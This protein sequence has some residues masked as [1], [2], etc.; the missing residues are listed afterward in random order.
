MLKNE[1]IYL[2]LIIFLSGCESIKSLTESIGFKSLNK[3]NEVVEKDIEISKPCNG[4]GFMTNNEYFRASAFGE[5]EDLRQ[6]QDKAMAEANDR[7]AAAIYHTIES[8]SDKYAASAG[9]NLSEDFK[10][11]I[12]SIAHDVVDQKLNNPPILCQ[13]HLKT[14]KGKYRT[15]AAIELTGNEII[16]GILQQ[17]SNDDK[18]N[19]DFQ[20]DKF[21]ENFEREMKKIIQ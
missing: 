9:S 6:A 18:L 8:A 12:G 21:K 2:L 14:E 20:H 5:G 17:I 13:K 10:K 1:L 3:K 16:E 7:L 15:Y 19:K 4:P 11:R